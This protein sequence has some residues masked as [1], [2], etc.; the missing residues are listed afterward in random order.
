MTLKTSDLFCRLL[1]LGKNNLYLDLFFGKWSTR[2]KVL[3][4]SG[5]DA[6]FHYSDKLVIDAASKTV[7]SQ[8]FK[9]VSYDKNKVRG[10]LFIGEGAVTI[11]SLLEVGFDQSRS[12]T[13]PL[14]DK[15]GKLTGSATVDLILKK[16]ADI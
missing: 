12:F 1:S 8:G 10:D 15:N 4:N 2:T 9:V 14:G 7:A 16:R 5:P 6:E 3:N 11:N 13:F